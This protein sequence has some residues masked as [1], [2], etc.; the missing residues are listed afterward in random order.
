MKLTNSKRNSLVYMLIERHII[1]T[2]GHGISNFCLLPVSPH[3]VRLGPRVEGEYIKQANANQVAA[4][5][6]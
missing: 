5:M 6:I 3:I 4:V 1:K 2:R